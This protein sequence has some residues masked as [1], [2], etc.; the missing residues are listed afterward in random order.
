MISSAGELIPLTGE[1]KFLQWAKLSFSTGAV[2]LIIHQDKGAINQADSARYLQKQRDIYCVGAEA[3]CIDEGESSA[4]IEPKLSLPTE[5]D[6]ILKN[7]TW[8]RSPA[9][10]GIRS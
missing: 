2:Q 10:A 3:I 7:T 8:A 4:T 9:F 1:Y 6:T 5:P